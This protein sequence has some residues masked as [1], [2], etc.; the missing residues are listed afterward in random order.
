MIALDGREESALGALQSSALIHTSLGL[1]LCLSISNCFGLHASKL[2]CSRVNVLGSPADRTMD[3]ARN[4][5]LGSLGL[6]A[7]D[8]YTVLPHFLVRPLLGL[9]LL[10]MAAEACCCGCGRG[11][12][13][14]IRA[15]K[16]PMESLYGHNP[17]TTKCEAEW[18]K[19][20]EKVN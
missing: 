12:H 20:E 17:M 1:G 6:R 18:A 4:V 15:L 5:C 2:P 9:H 16:K 11:E 13:G 19:A 3:F 10:N 14:R 8:W 7:R